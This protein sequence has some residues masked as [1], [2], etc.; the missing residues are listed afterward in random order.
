MSGSLRISIDLGKQS[1][2][3]VLLP[4]HSPVTW[5]VATHRGCCGSL[6]S[7]HIAQKALYWHFLPGRNIMLWWLVMC[8]LSLPSHH[9]HHSSYIVKSH[10]QSVSRKERLGGW[11]ELYE[12]KRTTLEWK[13]Q[14]ILWT[15]CIFRK[16]YVKIIVH[17]LITVSRNSNASE[18]NNLT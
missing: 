18:P 2:S 9:S 14:W 17:V 5:E 6:K 8:T 15:D 16:S 11:Q 12:K 4:L 1:S 10:T 3:K 7:R 13:I